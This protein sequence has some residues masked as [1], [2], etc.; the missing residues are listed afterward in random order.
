LTRP[1]DS[2]TSRNVYANGGAEYARS[3]K[4]RAPDTHARVSRG[5]TRTAHRAHAHHTPVGGAWCPGSNG[6]HVV[7]LRRAD[8]VEGFGV[9]A[10]QKYDG[11][12]LH[13]GLQHGR[14]R[15]EAN[16]MR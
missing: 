8:E 16:E 3:T 4:L 9:G 14:T 7:Q 15:R 13:E 1:N 2:S 11:R 5:H 12:V 6:V 10:L